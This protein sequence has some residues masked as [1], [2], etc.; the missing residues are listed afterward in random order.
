MIDH[1]EPC[2]ETI[3]LRLRACM[4]DADVKLASVPGRTHIDG[5][6][7]V[8]ENYFTIE[9]AGDVWLMRGFFWYGD[10]PVYIDRVTTPEGV[11]LRDA[12]A[13]MLTKSFVDDIQLRS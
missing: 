12:S 3:E 11:V 5:D 2:L 1:E 9:S 8:G 10:Y 13:S 4:K 6:A 7:F